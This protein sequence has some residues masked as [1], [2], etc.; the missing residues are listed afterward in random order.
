MRTDSPSR[1]IR[2]NGMRSGLSKASMVT[3]EM[4]IPTF[5]LLKLTQTIEVTPMGMIMAN[6]I[7]S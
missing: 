1:L 5:P 7:P 6:K 4:A 3:M 2:V